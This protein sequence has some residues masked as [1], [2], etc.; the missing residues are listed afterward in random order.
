MLDD[1]EGKKEATAELSFFLHGFEARAI[2]EG[3]G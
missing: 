2:E 1:Q 3:G